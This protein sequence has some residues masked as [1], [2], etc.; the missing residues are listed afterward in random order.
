MSP[1]LG[2]GKPP[3]AGK[4]DESR[5]LLVGGAHS[6]FSFS[7]VA[8]IEIEPDSRKSGGGRPQSKTL[9]RYPAL[10]ESR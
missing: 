7:V 2:A 3:T 9:S 1:L 5:S 4:R 8:G 10:R 6:V